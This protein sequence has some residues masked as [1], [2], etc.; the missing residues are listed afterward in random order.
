MP[1]YDTAR[2]SL[3]ESNYLSLYL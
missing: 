2:S 3:F 1:K